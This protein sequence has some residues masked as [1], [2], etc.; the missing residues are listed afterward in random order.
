M[1]TKSFSQSNLILGCH[2]AFLFPLRATSE[3]LAYKISALTVFRFRN[4]R[5]PTSRASKRA[6]LVAMYIAVAIKPS[7]YVHRL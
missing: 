4:T 3:Y 5:N 7:S 1:H 6:R 2:F